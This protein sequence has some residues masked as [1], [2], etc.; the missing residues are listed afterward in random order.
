[1]YSWPQDSLGYI[2]TFQVEIFAKR[3]VKAEKSEHEW[4]AFFVGEID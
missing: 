1:V 4:L 2:N 3:L